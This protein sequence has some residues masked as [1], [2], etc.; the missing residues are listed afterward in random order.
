M[1]HI[2]AKKLVDTMWLS[3]ALRPN[4]LGVDFDI[5]AAIKPF[6]KVEPGVLTLIGKSYESKKNSHLQQH[7]ETSFIRLNELVTLT[8]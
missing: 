4:V 7:L 6:L 8:N 1:K 5:L 2:K 3:F